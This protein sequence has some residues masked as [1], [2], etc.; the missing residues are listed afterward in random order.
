MTLSH[1]D[2]ER[3]F[4]QYRLL[5]KILEDLMILRGDLSASGAEW[6]LIA[7][8]LAHA[9]QDYSRCLMESVQAGVP[10]YMHPSVEIT[11]SAIK[12]DYGIKP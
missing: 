3:E 7:T 8:H 10:I 11:L 2:Y 12:E 1:M 5:Y 4:R 6:T 9:F